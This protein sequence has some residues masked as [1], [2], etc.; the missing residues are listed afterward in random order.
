[1]KPNLIS[2]FPV[3]RIKRQQGAFLLELT[4]VIP[5][6]L[7]TIA[8]TLGIGF[9]LNEQKKMTDAVQ[10]A[11]YALSTYIP[12]EAANI[13]QLC[14]TASNVIAGSV[15]KIGLNPA[16]FTFYVGGLN[17]NDDGGFA[18]MEGYLGAVQISIVRSSNYPKLFATQ[19]VVPKSV[20]G[21]FPL[22]SNF[23][24]PPRC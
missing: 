9:V 12:S 15:E 14:T 4:I 7:M 18:C 10:T 11:G 24:L 6:L 23:V 22:R 5:V 17:L 13:A 3:L 20:T 21:V 1:M 16:H 19:I 8:I 2:P